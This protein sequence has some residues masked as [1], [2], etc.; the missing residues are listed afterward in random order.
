MTA[1][2]TG[3]YGLVG[4]CDSPSPWLMI[5]RSLAAVSDPAPVSA[6][7]SGETPPRPCIPWHWTQPNWT[8][9]CAPDAIVGSTVS[10]ATLVVSPFLACL[11]S[12]PRKK[13][14]N[15]AANTRPST[16]R[17]TTPVTTSSGRSRFAIVA[18]LTSCR[19]RRNPGLPQPGLWK[20]RGRE[21]SKGSTSEP[22]RWVEW[23]GSC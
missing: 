14:K 3:M 11:E 15:P 19:A 18:T 4:F 22:G 10:T 13:P 8:N 23:R 6:G 20:E 9:R 17:I 2:Q 16:S 1:P 7:T 12:R 21:R 5:E